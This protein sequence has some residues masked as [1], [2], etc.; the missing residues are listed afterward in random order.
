MTNLRT[1]IMRRVY[2]I[3]FGRKVLPYI[4]VET[5]AFAGFVY[6]LGEQVYAA[7][8][9]EYATFVLSNNMAHPTVFASFAIDLFLRTHL[10]VQLSIIGSMAM[11]FFLFRNIIGSAV[12]LALTKGETELRSKTL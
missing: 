5:V 4:A 10:G 11:I 8:V 6:F 9:M 2:L 12:Q 7:R 3:W 1:K